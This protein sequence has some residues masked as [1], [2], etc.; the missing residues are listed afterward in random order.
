MPTYGRLPVAFTHGEGCYLFDDNGKKYFD[1]LTGIAVCGLGHAHPKV[2]QA[3]QEQA[4]KVLHTSNLYEIPQQSK[5]AD[6]LC[7][8]TG[9]TNV[10]FGNSGAEANECAIKLARKFGNDKGIANPTIITT[11]GSF[12]GR[13]IATLSAT[14]NPK[15]KTGFS[16]LV[17]GFVEVP[18]NDI[19]AIQ[20]QTGN[21]DIVAIMVEPA[22]G[23]GGINIPDTDYLNQLRDICDQQ[24][25]LLI[26]DEIQTGNGRSG[27]L[28][29][30]EHNAITPDVLTTAKGLGNGLPIGACLTYGKA[31]TVI[32][33][34][35]H[36]STFGGNPLVCAGANAVMD[37]LTP[38]LLQHVHEIGAYLNEQFTAK[39]AGLSVIKHVRNMGLLVGIELHK[40]CTDLV[41]KALEHGVLINV[42]QQTVVR[43]LPP[44][45]MTNADVDDLVEILAPLIAEYEEITACEE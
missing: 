18:F 43:L 30:F 15:V 45:I 35:N 16:P 7:Q 37:E 38:S 44:L 10:F 26:V 34:G 14:G 32:Q 28:F 23:E 3:I 5:L 25:W 9:M 33:A 8:R 39:L 41:A 11:T 29:A 31:S 17:S 20:A 6:S 22:Q 21:A 12:H 2:T 24:D 13:T 27:K 1:A 19:S 4:A 42:T 36:G 40:P